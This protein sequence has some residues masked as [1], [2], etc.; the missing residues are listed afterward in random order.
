MKVVELET[1][2]WLIEFNWIKVHAGHH[3]NELAD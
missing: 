1:Q 2:N 3:G